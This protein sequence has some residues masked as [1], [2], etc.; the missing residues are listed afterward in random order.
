MDGDG[1]VTRGVLH[2]SPRFGHSEIEMN[3]KHRR[4]RKRTAQQ[5]A[6]DARPQGVVRRDK[7]MRESRIDVHQ[8]RVAPAG[9]SV[10]VES[11]AADQVVPTRPVRLRL[12]PRRLHE[13]RFDVR[14]SALRDGALQGTP[15]KAG[16]ARW[17]GPSHSPVVYE[18]AHSSSWL[19]WL[20]PRTVRGMD[21][22][23]KVA[24]IVSACVVIALSISAVVL[25]ATWARATH[26]AWEHWTSDRLVRKAEKYFADGDYGS[27][28]ARANKAYLDCPENE[29]AI[30]ILG[31]RC[32]EVG[33]AEAMFFYDRLERM[34]RLTDEDR[35]SKVS[36][37]IQRSQWKEAQTLAAQLLVQGNEN[38]RLIAL[39]CTLDNAGYTMPPSLRE[40]ARKRLL[41]CGSS[42]EVLDLACLWMKSDAADERAEADACLWRLA[43]SGTG[44]TA[45]KAAAALNENL[46]A[47][48]PRSIYLA[49]LMSEMPYSESQHRIAALS[50]L[51]GASPTARVD[52][53]LQ[54]MLKTWK[55]ES[56]DDRSLLGRLIYD[57]ARPQLL[58]GLFTRAEA[59]KTPRAAELYVA[60]LMSAG[61]IED[62]LAVLKD[63]H[64]LVSR[65]QRAYAEA[66]LAILSG[67]AADDA[68]HRLLC[69]FGAAS[70]EADPVLLTGVAELAM[71]RSLPSVAFQAY[72]ECLTIHNSEAVALDGLIAVCDATGETDKLKDTLDRALAR[73]PTD[74]RYL[75]M[76]VYVHLLMGVEMEHSFLVAERLLAVRPEDDMRIFLYS[77]AHARLGNTTGAQVELRRL[78]QKGGIPMR[79]L[80]VIGGLLKGSGDSTTASKAVSGIF[81]A[82]VTLPE[83]KAFLALAKL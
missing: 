83:E 24:R 23:P 63:R 7:R 11:E 73:W 72:E 12:M 19:D 47:G 52:A 61:K 56:V 37:L 68:R 6:P 5:E 78:Y 31:R 60:G 71:R 50:R 77:M 81:E 69:A 9:G 15:N 39:G 42:K 20:F 29:D 51:L 25:S 74:E 55:N 2:C 46:S 57:C 28:F 3:P 58:N 4:S 64:L 41:S 36:A 10:V 8:A 32:E 48:D 14:P 13:K 70:A 1:F 75:E 76:S 22:Q 44:L 30:R 33:A 53:L 34:D 16:S 49:W 26:D 35:I 40:R 38:E 80:A 66:K 27:G 18:T 65:A 17:Y 54:D 82:D 79:Y 43:E 67:C 45:R 59:V 62:C 21:A